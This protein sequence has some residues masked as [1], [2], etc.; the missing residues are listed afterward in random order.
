MK[1]WLVSSV[2]ACTLMASGT[3]IYGAE[4]TLDKAAAKTEAQP[5]KGGGAKKE[6]RAKFRPFT[7]K[8]K[9]VNKA[10]QT[11]TLEGGKAQTFQVTSETKINKEGKPATFDDLAVGEIARGRALDRDGKWEAV[12]LNLGPQAAR[13]GK[14]KKEKEPTPAKPAAK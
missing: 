1:T 4:A 8:I 14:P 10:A 9:E 2:L 3:P 12:K 13:P 7:G 11:L 5:K 6:S